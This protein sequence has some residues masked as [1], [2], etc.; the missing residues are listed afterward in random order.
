[1]R[2]RKKDANA[3]RC[4]ISTRITEQQKEVLDKNKFI[5][6]EIDEMIRKYVDNYL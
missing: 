2:G 4:V 5:K 3:K 1:M 6:K